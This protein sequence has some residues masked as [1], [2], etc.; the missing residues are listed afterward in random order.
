MMDFL[1]ALAPSHSTAKTRA[2]P[3][4]LSRFESRRPLAHV[5]T[6]AVIETPGHD[7]AHGVR[8]VARLPEPAAGGGI[9]RTS[10][11]DEEVVTPASDGR[12]AALP[13]AEE[14]H[15][16][17]TSPPVQVRVDVNTGNTAEPAGQVRLMPQA[18]EAIASLRAVPTVTT[19]RRAPA[20]TIGRDV[21]DVA[22]PQNGHG[23]LSPGA[24]AARV[25]QPAEIRPVIHVTID[26]I[27]VRAPAGPERASSRPR[28]RANASGSLTD[29]LRSRQNGRPG[30]AS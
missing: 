20:L 14:A 13:A 17:S 5:M 30:G 10:P 4:V 29:Y 23:P 6:A 19:S 18:N 27:D 11:T 2:L 8:R 26:R 3:V 9:E 25:A 28:P 22:G 24:V 21:A 12:L 15:T 16:R 1:R 7:P